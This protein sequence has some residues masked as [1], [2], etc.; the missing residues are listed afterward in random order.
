[1]PATFDLSSYDDVKA[2]ADKIL[3]RLADG[4]MPF[5]RPRAEDQMALFVSGS[6]PAIRR[7]AVSEVSPRLSRRAADYGFLAVAGGRPRA[8]SRNAVGASPWWRL[9]AR[10]KYS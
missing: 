5:D 1:M 10:E 2:S 9:N 6:P 7:Q 3:E 8:R 4:L